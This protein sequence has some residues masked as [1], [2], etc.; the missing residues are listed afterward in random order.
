MGWAARDRLGQFLL[1]K[2]SDIVFKILK[3]LHAVKYFSDAKYPIIIN[4]IKAMLD[5]IKPNELLKIDAHL[6]KDK[7]VEWVRNILHFTIS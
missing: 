6:G 2:N 4:Y 3:A 1:G 7:Q 5:I